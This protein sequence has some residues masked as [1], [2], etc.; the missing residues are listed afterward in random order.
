MNRKLRN[1]LTA[2]T[3]CGLA[4]VLALVGISPSIQSGDR[5]ATVHQNTTP[6]PD[7]LETTA[8]TG[9]TR[10]GTALP[11]DIQPATDPAPP[12][13]TGGR[14]DNRQPLVMPYFS[15]APRG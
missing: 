13:R 6:A 9:S 2:L 14:R 15:F 3:T 10:S 7:T 8:S 5:P 4:V 12:T 1:S 11:L